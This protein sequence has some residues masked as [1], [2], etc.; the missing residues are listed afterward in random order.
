MGGW[1]RRFALA[2]LIVFGT[3]SAAAADPLVSQ[4][5]AGLR[6][7]AQAAERV[8]L[9]V[10]N[11]NGQPVFD[12]GAVP[13]Q[14]LQWNLQNNAGQLVANGVYLYRVTTWN[15]AGQATSSQIRKLFVMR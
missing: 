3:V 4:K 11:L 1:R 2:L 8:E 12:S 9:Q 14:T 13:G 6:V 10:Y 15:A 7:T 5:P